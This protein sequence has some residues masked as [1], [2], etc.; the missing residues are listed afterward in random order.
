MVAF[1]ARLLLR[2]RDIRVTA[3]DNRVQEAG[4]AMRRSGVLN[5]RLLKTSLL[6]DGS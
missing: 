4:A 3:F 6:L 5:S 2:P 1:T